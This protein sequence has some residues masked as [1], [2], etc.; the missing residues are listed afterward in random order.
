MHRI[1]VIQPNSYVCIDFC[2]KRATHSVIRIALR[3][4][5]STR[6]LALTF[7]ANTLRILRYSHHSTVF[8]LNLYVCIDFCSKPVA[9]FASFGLHYGTLLSH[10]HSLLRQMNH[11]LFTLQYCNSPQL[12]GLTLAVNVSR[13]L[14]YSH[15][16]AVIH[17][18]SN[19][20][21]DFLQ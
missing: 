13:I 10:L 4:F 16:F 5:Y 18:T 8:P 3:K 20:H 12:F 9:C 17:P 21:I 11:S 2:C 14:H 15:W 6:T 1:T 19:I 7:A